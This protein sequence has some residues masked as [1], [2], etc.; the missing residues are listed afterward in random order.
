MIK[1]KTQKSPLCSQP[2]PRHQAGLRPWAGGWTDGRRGPQP[3]MKDGGRGGEAI[4]CKWPP[5]HLGKDKEGGSDPATEDKG[6]RDPGSGGSRDTRRKRTK[7]GR[8]PCRRRRTGATGAC[9]GSLRPHRGHGGHRVPRPPRTSRCHTA[10]GQGTPQILQNT[11][12]GRG[13]ASPKETLWPL[14]ASAQSP[15]G[16]P[17]P[18]WLPSFQ[19]NLGTSYKAWARGSACAFPATVPVSV[20]NGK[21]GPGD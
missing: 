15:A 8:Q 11:R 20:Q 2:P 13:V 9:G 19:D 4:S 14:W 12:H 21:W 10:G 18:T 7:P 1:K 6:S 16:P 17:A 5:G 3:K